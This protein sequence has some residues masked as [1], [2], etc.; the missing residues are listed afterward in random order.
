MAF[1][2][3][4]IGRNGCTVRTAASSRVGPANGQHEEEEDVDKVLG[5]AGEADLLV[6]LKLH[7]QEVGGGEAGHGRDGGGDKVGERDREAPYKV[8]K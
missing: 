5:D 3:R 6:D 7:V 8:D 1:L 2:W 4:F